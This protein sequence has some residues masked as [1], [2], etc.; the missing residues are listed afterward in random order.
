[1]G[2]TSERWGLREVGRRGRRDT[3]GEGGGEGESYKAGESRG[4]LKGG[5]CE[6]RG[7]GGGETVGERG[8]GGR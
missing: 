8:L 4:S 5:V 7:G 1:L 2:V 3:E 6:G